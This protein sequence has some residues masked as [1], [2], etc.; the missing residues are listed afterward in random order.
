MKRLA[1][2]AA[3]IGT[4]ALAQ[5]STAPSSPPVGID[6]AGIDRSVKPGDDF[7]A[8]A[9]GGWRART[10]IPADRAS[11]GVFL[12]VFSKSEKRNAELIENAGESR[13]AAGSDARKLADY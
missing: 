3:L 2:L 1:L 10:T 9:N 8:Y 12:D 13:P 7:D 4:T 6:T 11:T 5:T